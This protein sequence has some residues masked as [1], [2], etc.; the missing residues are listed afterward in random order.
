MPTPPPPIHTLHQIFVAGLPLWRESAIAQR[1]SLPRLERA[2]WRVDL[3]AGSDSAATVGEPRILLNLALRPQA[4]R[5]D[6]MAPVRNVDVEL[7]PATLSTLVDG[8][9]RIAVQLEGLQR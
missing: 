8:M 6:A 1:V 3:V 5:T 7:T 4:E 9:K 2:H